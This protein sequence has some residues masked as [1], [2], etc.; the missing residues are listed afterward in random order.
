VAEVVFSLKTV[1]R[2]LPTGS[3]AFVDNHNALHGRSRFSD[4]ERHLIR[5]RVA[6]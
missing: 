5:V 4:A 6:A 2:K 1:D 3:I